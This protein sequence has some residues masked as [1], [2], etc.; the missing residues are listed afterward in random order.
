VEYSKLFLKA[1][2]YQKLGDKKAAVQYYQKC[3]SLNLNDPAIFINL[4]MMYKSED[5]IISI[6]ALSIAYQL[7]P[8]HPLCIKS[9]NV[10]SKDFQALKN[11]EPS[12]PSKLLA[13]TL[14]FF[15]EEN[16]INKP[17][18]IR[19][20]MDFYN[21]G[22]FVNS[23]VIYR[24]IAIIDTEI[25]S[26][27]QENIALCCHK[28]GNWTEADKIYSKLYKD[29]KHNKLT[30]NNY[31]IFLL[32]TN[33]LERA[34]AIV[35]EALKKFPDYAEAWNTKGNILAR[36]NKSLNAIRCYTNALDIEPGNIEFST[37]LANQLIT[38]GEFKKSL[39]LLQSSL[40][41]ENISVNILKS[42]TELTKRPLEKKYKEWLLEKLLTEECE[43]TKATIEF[44]L[45]RSAE[46]EKDHEAAFF[47]YSNGN[48]IR[49]QILKF[50]LESYLSKID[51]TLQFQNVSNSKQVREPYDPIF[52]LGLPR[53]GTSL[54]EQMLAMC[55]D[56]SALGELNFI[57]D[58]FD[59]YDVNMI[60]DF[61]STS[62][63]RSSYYD[64]VHRVHEPKIKFTDKMP[65]NYQYANILL[66][67]FSTSKLLML[68]R[69][70]LPTIWS[71]YST[72]FASKGNK[73]AY[74][75]SEIASVYDHYF[76]FC[77]KITKK[78]PDRVMIVDY[79]SI[80]DAPE[81]YTKSIA[82]FI[83]VSW[84]KNWLEFSE[85][86]RA[87]NTASGITL[88]DGLLTRR[89][90]RWTN[91]EVFIKEQLV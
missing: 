3:L 42:Y 86:K 14:E 51:S 62:E 65:L 85:N 53:T 41:N 75:I 20:A 47:H 67:T 28:I 32:E 81:A 11:E 22:Q 46:R 5:S 74:S 80:I 1:F 71:I 55:E 35:E 27:L 68:R 90:H 84:T 31:A 89:D 33:S 37:N 17:N 21:K 39:K 43:E 10:R 76:Q 57:C 83:G 50:D 58:F 12:Q 60:K 59:T 16:N 45:A 18:L 77:N 34:K 44:T 8:N 2:E 88:R 29:K 52:V 70:K 40:E 73:F 78:Y 26:H 48:R 38:T 87:V 36:M 66:N 30:L 69:D 63:L 23:Y 24:F 7:S 13:K 25:N 19:K 79:S 64:Y 54:V 15:F 61:T 9:I 91:Y 4:H 82:D 56:I 72:N 49:K 6:A